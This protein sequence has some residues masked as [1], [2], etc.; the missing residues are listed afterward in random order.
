VANFGGTLTITNSTIAG[1]SASGALN[2][3]SG[4]GV[5]NFGGTLTI[6]NSTIAGNSASG[7]YG[8]SGGG[9]ANGYNGTL[10]VTNSTISGNTA[11]S[12]GGGVINGLY[13]SGTLTL[14][15]TL[16]S[17]NTATTGP[18]I[19]NSVPA[20]TVVADNH[21]LFGADGTVGVEGFTPGATDIVPPAGV[22][23]P[24]ILD[25]TLAF[26][27]G[28]TQTYALV[29]GSPA[30]DAGGT[31]CTDVNGD[32]LPTDQRGRPRVVDGTGDGTAACDIGAVEFFPLVNDFVTLD[33]ALDTSFDP[34]PVPAGPAGT[35]TITAT[36]TNT[37]DTPLRFPF[38]TVT[39][40]SGGNLLL[41]AEADTQGI[42]ATLTPDVGDSVLA[43][44]EAVTVDFVLGL[45][46]QA[47]FTF[48]VDLF[49]E[50]VH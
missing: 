46:A 36:F 20:G 1:N 32:P 26:N 49:G 6:T 18:E 38:F 29:P 33:P 19:H 23:L 5:A 47:P 16:I 35:F 12:F 27:G 39:E 28:H 37:S 40:L 41:N 2:P 21:N 7:F 14:A 15:R 22:Q 24:D 10:A 45:Q 43:P 25:P 11:N 50:P 8:G 42:G 13:G 17:G 4:G 9:V 44:G 30:I 3:S 48:F 31:D 34:T